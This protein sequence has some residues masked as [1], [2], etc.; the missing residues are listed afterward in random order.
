MATDVPRE[1]LEAQV[2]QLREMV[3]EL[4]GENRRRENAAFA[5]ILSALREN[6][7]DLEPDSDWHRRF[8]VLGFEVA[9]VIGVHS[10]VDEFGAK[11]RFG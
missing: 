2:Y 4:N 5:T 3:E 9:Q 10:T 8:L 7:P 1:Q 11:A 6:V